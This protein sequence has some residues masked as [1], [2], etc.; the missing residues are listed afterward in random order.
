[1][2]KFEHAFSMI[3]SIED[4]AMYVPLTCQA[5]YQSA[6]EMMSIVERHSKHNTV[7]M[8]LCE[9]GWLLFVRCSLVGAN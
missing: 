3:R 7:A 9:R 6:S 2:P 8:L 4:L 1:V 5:E